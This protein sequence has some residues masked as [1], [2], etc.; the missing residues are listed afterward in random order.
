MMTSMIYVEV[1][2]QRVRTAQTI[3][4]SGLSYI[5]TAPA[6]VVAQLDRLRLMLPIE[7]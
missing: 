5:G 1:P 2:P 3:Y 7:I 4:K 6:A